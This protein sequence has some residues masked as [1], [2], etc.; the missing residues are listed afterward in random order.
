MCIRLCDSEISACNDGY[1]LESTNCFM[2]AQSGATSHTFA[3]L[4][5]VF[6]FTSS[7]PVFEA[8]DQRCDGHCG[9]PHAVSTSETIRHVSFLPKQLVD[10]S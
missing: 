2:H 5:C 10:L 3:D 1:L 8:L 9:L 7:W 6:L 4:S